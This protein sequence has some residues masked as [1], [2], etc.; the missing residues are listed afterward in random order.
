[1]ELVK[2]SGG[3]KEEFLGL[4]FGGNIV[5]SVTETTFDALG[6]PPTIPIFL[7]KIHNPIIIGNNMFPHIMCLWFIKTSDLPGA[8][9]QK[10]MAC[11]DNNL[12]P[13]MGNRNLFTYT[14]EVF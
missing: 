4:V 1:M 7:G 9:Q 6:C 2:E 11:T 8:R 12:M 5:A 3:T 13:K 14:S 10:A